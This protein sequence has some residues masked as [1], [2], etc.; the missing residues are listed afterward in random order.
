M[1]T[2]KQQENLSGGVPR[3]GEPAEDCVKRIEKAAE[4][5]ET[6]CG[7]GN[8]IWHK[9]GEGAPGLMFHGNHGSWS[10]WIRNI[11]VLSQHYAVYCAD[12]PGLGDSALPPKPY[13]LDAIIDALSF[14]VERIVPADAKLHVVGFSYGSAI[15]ANTAW[16]FIDLSLIHI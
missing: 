15:A 2:D 9:W 11:P 13:S 12:A 8:L 3:L 1:L 10:H 7:D 4:V 5:F 6:P 14:G 16:R